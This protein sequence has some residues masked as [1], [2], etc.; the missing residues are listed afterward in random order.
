M[1]GM[2]TKE[3]ILDLWPLAILL[4]SVA[5]LDLD[6]STEVNDYTE[7]LRTSPLSIAERQSHNNHGVFYDVQYLGILS[8]M[9]R[10]N[11][12]IRD[13]ARMYLQ[14]T[15]IPRLLDQITLEGAQPK[16]LARKTSWYYSFFAL[17]GW[18]YLAAQASFFDVDLWAVKHDEAKVPVL[19]S[20][21]TYLLRHAFSSPP[22][23]NWPVF[24]QKKD[25]RIE[26]QFRDLFFYAAEAYKVQER[27]DSL[28]VEW[29]R[30]VD[31]IASSGSSTR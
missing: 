17:R 6:N 7:S 22:G 20:A 28:S 21:F 24:D 4:Q 9:M 1:R 25:F 19:Q 26:S 14:E 11:S 2:G 3:G 23:R 10:T 15:T 18:T 31:V 8:F 27:H 16:E 13:T 30:W 12:S 29:Q 5:G